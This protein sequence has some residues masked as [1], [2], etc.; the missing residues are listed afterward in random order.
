MNIKKHIQWLKEQRKG[1]SFAFLAERVAESADAPYRF[2]VASP[3]KPDETLVLVLGGTGACGSDN[4]RGYNGYAKKV[5][6]FLKTRSEL[7]NK[8]FRVCVAVCNAGHY[9]DENVARE[10]KFLQYIAPETYRKFYENKQGIELQEFINPAYI[11]DIF[12]LAVLPRISASDGKI[13]LSKAQALR[14]IRRL[15]IVTHC[16]GAYVASCLEEMMRDKMQRLGYSEKE[17]KEIQKQ[18]MVLNYA[19]DYYRRKGGVRFIDFESAADDHAKYQPTFK[20]WI[21]MKGKKFSLFYENNWFMCGQ[22][23]KA[24][25]EGNPP[26]VLVAKKIDGNYFEEIVAA[27]KKAKEDEM[28]E[29]EEE[30]TLS[31][32]AFL[33]FKPKSN[34]SKAA[35]KMQIFFGNVLKNAVLNSCEQP[36]EGFSPLPSTKRL[37]ADTASEMLEI[38]KAWCT[39]FRLIEQFAHRNNQKLNQ[40]IAWHQ[41]SRITLD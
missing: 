30:A 9:H 11:Q 33:G 20:E 41:N 36:K 40:Y 39:N 2:N 37:M 4:I 6:D 24:G 35:L 22:I 27:R 21:Q 1:L 12:N 10:K 19:G 31:E 5:S 13:R 23:D 8:N 3:I 26:R 38:V 14:N 25:I 17:Q 15:N 32:H 34:M 29:P 7:K 16:H 28:K 18:L